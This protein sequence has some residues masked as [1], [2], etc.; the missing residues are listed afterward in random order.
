MHNARM[1]AA[2]GVAL[3]VLAAPAVAQSPSPA[4]TPRLP[5]TPAG[6][7]VVPG[8]VGTI[9][10]RAIA[11]DAP[12]R[13]GVPEAALAG[14]LKRPSLVRT[15]IWLA[16]DL[17]RQEIASPDFLL[18]A[19]TL[20]LHKAGE[21][22]YVVADPAQKT[23]TVM[24]G[25]ALLDLVEGS[26]G[27]VDSRYEA[28]VQHTEERKTIAGYPARRSVVTVSYVSTVPYESGSVLV[29]RKTDI[30]VWH[31][32]ALVSA[33]A[34][35]HLFFKFQRDKTGAVRDAVA[36][37]IGFPLEMKLVVTQGQKAAVQPGS[38]HMT[39]LEMQ[40]EGRLDS[41]LFRIPPAGFRRVEKL[42]FAPK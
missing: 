40:K 38:F 12:A 41:E 20:V 8:Y 23:F 5:G 25:E 15:K 21:R 17:S 11:P 33:A 7:P 34:V 35:D 13:G 4:A 37:E 39:V 30:E 31:T 18:P 42:P 26:A 10:V 16:Q 3:L 32:S 36:D 2:A 29:Q 22:A 27:V 19:G 24:D 6:P 28:K 14:A 9:E 1:S